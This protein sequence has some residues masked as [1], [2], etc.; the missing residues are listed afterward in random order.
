MD[1]NLGSIIYPAYVK[2][3]LLIVERLID[4]FNSFSR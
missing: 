3:D 1:G 2:F 4:E